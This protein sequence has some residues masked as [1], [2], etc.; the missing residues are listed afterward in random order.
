M[1]IKE[2]SNRPVWADEEWLQTYS[3][4][5]SIANAEPTETT[6]DFENQKTAKLKRQGQEAVEIAGVRIILKYFLISK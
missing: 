5:E 2:N 1:R 6:A 3:G 4:K